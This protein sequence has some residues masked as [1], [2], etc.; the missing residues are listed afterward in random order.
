MICTDE[1]YQEIALKC[2]ENM[3]DWD[4]EVLRILGI[5]DRQ[6]CDLGSANYQLQNFIYEMVEKYCEENNID[7]EDFDYEVDNILFQEV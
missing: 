2:K 6:R 4:N 3:E 1:I 5:M 7:I